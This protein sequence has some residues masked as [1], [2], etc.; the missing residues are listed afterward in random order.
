M[1]G[2]EE[3]IMGAFCAKC[4]GPLL[5]DGTC[6]KCSSPFQAA[7]DLGGGMSEKRP[8][9]PAPATARPEP[10]KPAAAPRPAA[11]RPAASKPETK[12]K[13]AAAPRAERRP[14]KKK[15]RG[16]KR[17]GLLI[18]TLALV[19]A[20]TVGVVYFIMNRAGKPQGAAN[21]DAQEPAGTGKV[22]I[23]RDAIKNEPP[24]GEATLPEL[25]VDAYFKKL[26][27]IESVDS[28]DA[29]RTESETM[30]DLAARGFGEQPI[31]V[32]YASDGSV[33]DEEKEISKDSGDAHPVYETVYV[34]EKGAVWRITVTN[35]ELRAEP[36]TFIQD[37]GWKTPVAL[38]EHE[39]M[40][41]NDTATTEIYTILPDPDAYVLKTVERID[42]E[43]LED[44]TA[45]EVRGL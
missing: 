28:A 35:G 3:C 31:T 2:K 11:P 17:I 32:L 33:L 10:P 37:S 1:R 40:F 23:D 9:A 38:S 5:P 19:A 45:G 25:D 41:F 12:G 36:V 14:E 27:E 18:L 34:T 42:A 44:L 30:R 39:T 22:E 26:G 16:G 7:G 6:P 24:E 4:G 8:A 43:F 13:K 15:G 29:Q 20:A 21:A